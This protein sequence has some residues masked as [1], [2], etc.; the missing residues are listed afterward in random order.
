MAA[1]CQLEGLQ[2]DHCLGGRLALFRASFPRA[3]S[4]PGRGEATGSQSL[5][6]NHG[7]RQALESPPSVGHAG[8][9]SDTASHCLGLA[10]HDCPLLAASWLILGC[11]CRGCC[12]HGGALP[13]WGEGAL[14]P[15]RAMPPEGEEGRECPESGVASSVDGHGPTP[16]LAASPCATTPPLGVQKSNLLASGW[17]EFRSAP[18]VVR[19][20]RY[21]AETTPSW[22]PH[23]LPP[24]CAPSTYESR[25]QGCGLRLCS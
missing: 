10:L 25:A 19:L 6:C 12:G 23:F 5:P 4:H 13:P 3:A 1:R 22:L 18:Y 14:C 17:D 21:P 8:M 9:L 2:K 24:S 7:P 11:W 16:Y 20:R 15:A